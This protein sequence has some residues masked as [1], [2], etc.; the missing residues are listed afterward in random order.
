MF[1]AL[2]I[3]SPE[4]E[5]SFRLG[6]APRLSELPMLF[7][8][9]LIGSGEEIIGGNMVIIAKQQQVVDGQL[10]CAALIARVHRLGGAEHGGNFLLGFVVILAQV[11]HPLEIRKSQHAAPF[12]NEHSVVIITSKKVYY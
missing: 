5:L 2:S 9:S 7:F 4:S 12:F 8:L 11:A 6:R 3:G 1:F 10:V